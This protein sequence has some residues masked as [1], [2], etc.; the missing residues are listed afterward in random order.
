MRAHVL[1]NL[2]NFNK[3]RKSDIM[4][5]LPSILSLFCNEFYIFI[6]TGAQ[7]F[8]RFYI[9]YDISIALKSYQPSTNQHE[10]TCREQE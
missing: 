2:F 3:L 8:K 7:L 4:C 6:Y 5:G 10:L 9:S 1:L